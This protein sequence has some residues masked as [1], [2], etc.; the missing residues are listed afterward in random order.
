MLVFPG[1]SFQA[2]TKTNQFWGPR[3]TWKWYF[4]KDTFHPNAVKIP[5]FNVWLPP[6]FESHPLLLLLL[7]LLWLLLLLLL[8]VKSLNHSVVASPWGVNNHKRCQGW[9]L[10]FFWGQLGPWPWDLGSKYV[11]SKRKT[12]DLGGGFKDFLFSSRSL[13]KISNLTNIFQMGWNHQLGMCCV[14]DGSIT[15]WECHDSDSIG[16]YS[17]IFRQHILTY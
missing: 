13:G 9:R 12:V 1:V 11:H 15:A 4:R 7:L 2:T 17:M 6:F 3:E 14:S 10:I 8:L 5:G 16:N